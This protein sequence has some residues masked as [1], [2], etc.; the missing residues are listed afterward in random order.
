MRT[1]L[2]TLALCIGLLAACKGQ[3][4]AT[5]S[6]AP[7]AQPATP[8]AVEPDASPSP[9]TEVNDLP[10]QGQPCPQGACAAGLSCLR[11]YG[12]AGASGP[13]FATCELP[14]AGNPNAC[15]SD[16]KC[17]VIADGPGQVCKPL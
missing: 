9:A 14:C 16:Q 6:A 11:Y 12:I 17:V 5:P 1:T 7:P 2:Y 10:Q 4:H 13:A 8:V 15:P 3:P